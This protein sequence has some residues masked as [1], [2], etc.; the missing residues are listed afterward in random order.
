MSK[1]YKLE[2]VISK[3]LVLAIFLIGALVGVGS[4]M[5]LRI[6][7]ASAQGTGNRIGASAPFSAGAISATTVTASGNI[8]STVGSGANAISFAT[9]GARLDLGAGSV[10]YVISDGTG[11]QLPGYLNINQGLRNTDANEGVAVVD[12]VGLALE[13]VATASLV[14]CNSTAPSSG[15]TR[16]AV[17]YDTTSSSYKI[18][19]G[20][21]WVGL[22]ETEYQLCAAGAS[23]AGL[24]HTF[25]NLPATFVEVGNSASQ[26]NI[27]FAKYTQFRIV[28]LNSVAAVTGDIE[29]Q[30]DADV[31]FGSAA[32][33]GQQT[34]PTTTL[35]AGAWT[36]IPAGECLTVGGVFV[37]AGMI[38]GNTT[39]DPAVR[40]IR[41]QLR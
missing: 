36:A 7:E 21:A 8:N 19:N 25:T 40:F 17:Q 11:L 13:G 39:E 27:D 4:F 26:N 14:A 9:N 1:P 29:I 12:D 20:T 33:L 18:C 37:R 38:N 23:A 5:A 28:S 15:G 3:N 35:T 34:N 10:D 2:S 6:D 30:C 16:G 24:C 22:V 31:A 41:L 32:V